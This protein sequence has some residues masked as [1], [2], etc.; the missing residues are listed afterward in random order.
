MDV[1]FACVGVCAS[2]YAEAE[3]LSISVIILRE[4]SR[5]PK[6]PFVFWD[7]SANMILT[8]HLT[9]LWAY[10][11][12][13]RMPMRCYAH[14][15]RGVEIWFQARLRSNRSASMDY[16]QLCHCGLSIFSSTVWLRITILLYICP[17]LS[18]N[19]LEG[20]EFLVQFLSKISLFSFRIFRLCL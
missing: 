6:L 13:P 9:L 12:L 10:F 2:P 14:G 16:G 1:N 4:Q 8:Q 18:C 5:K 20:D 17:S 15:A 3:F 19:K 11:D 7:L